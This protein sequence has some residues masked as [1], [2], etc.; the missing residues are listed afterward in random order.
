MPVVV[1]LSL[2]ERVAK[3]ELSVDKLLA[4]MGARFGESTQQTNLQTG[5]PKVVR[6]VESLHPL[7]IVPPLVSLFED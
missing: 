4:M 6:R 3:I 7:S 5:S 1:S 2:N